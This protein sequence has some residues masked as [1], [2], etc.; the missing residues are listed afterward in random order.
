MSGA[1]AVSLILATVGRTA[2][3]HRF[4]DALAQ[5]TFLDAELIIVDQNDD[6]RLVPL[7]DP[8]RSCMTVHHLRSPRGLSRARNIG[9]AASTGM[10]I[11]FPDD[12]CWYPADLLQ[13]LSRR[14]A[15]H[16]EVDGW[17]GMTKDANEQPSGSRW[18]SSKN[19][20]TKTNV[21]RR[22]MSPAIFLRRS[23]VETIGRFNESLG[24]GAGTIWGSGE[25]T[26]YL[27]RG[28]ERGLQMVYDPSI[29]VHHPQVEMRDRSIGSTRARSY[30]MGFGWVLR[31]HQ[32]P[33]AQVLY[34]WMRAMGGAA[35][36]LARGD[37]DRA[38]F[39]WNVALG[40]I[41]GYITATP[42]T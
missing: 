13:Q 3:L 23:A 33:L 19:R 35:V 25:E 22:A 24:V 15:D 41:W 39:S 5:Q 32:F 10:L 21:W 8:I 20:L 7:L 27:L 16:P 1:P 11:A 36:Y 9:L 42:L 12:D 40:R 17:T 30:G 37:L 31:R 2:E 4:L 14:F 26:D 28:L 29:V 18:A 38:R 6:D 34:H